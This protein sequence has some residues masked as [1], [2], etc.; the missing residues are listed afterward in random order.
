MLISK[1]IEK[2]ANEEDAEVDQM[3]QQ[4]LRQNLNN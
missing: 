3:E 4:E 1:E 2:I